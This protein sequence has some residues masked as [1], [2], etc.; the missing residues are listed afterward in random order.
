MIIPGYSEALLVSFN[1]D[2]AG[3]YDREHI[4]NLFKKV[5]SWFP[6]M[7]STHRVLNNRC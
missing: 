3:P 4:N 2:D 1:G 5:Q 6:S 7:L